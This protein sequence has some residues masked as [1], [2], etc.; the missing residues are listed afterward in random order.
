MCSHLL[1]PEPSGPAPPRPSSAAAAALAYEKTKSHAVQEA[2]PGQGYKRSQPRCLR[3]TN[4]SWDCLHTPGSKAGVGA[5]QDSGL[6]LLFPSFFTSY[7]VPTQNEAGEQGQDGKGGLAVCPIPS[8]KHPQ[9]LLPTPASP[10]R[11]VSLLCCR[12]ESYRQGS[13]GSG[14]T[15]S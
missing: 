8:N 13:I 12:L 14:F 7:T 11:E 3:D 5:G 1:L 6:L 15:R 4:A 10:P 9:F 2:D